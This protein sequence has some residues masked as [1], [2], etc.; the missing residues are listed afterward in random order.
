MA[1]LHQN[2]LKKEEN[3]VA[4]GISAADR[5]CIA[6]LCSRGTKECSHP[7]NAYFIKNEAN[8]KT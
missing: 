4:A 3:E 8:N 7:A 1:V 2:T 6:V 5:Q